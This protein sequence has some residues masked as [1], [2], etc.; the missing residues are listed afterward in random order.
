LRRTAVLTVMVALASVSVWAV[1]SGAIASPYA[2][3]V[4]VPWSV[5]AFVAITAMTAAPV[6]WVG[7]ADSRLLLT[8]E[9]SVAAPAALL[10][11]TYLA[12]ALVTLA[13]VAGYGLMLVR[14]SG[15][16]QPRANG[17]H[18]L[19]RACRG[20]MLV[21]AVVLVGDL[22]GRPGPGL[23]TASV[24]LGWA[25]WSATNAALTAIVSRPAGRS[26]PW[27]RAG[28]AVETVDVVLAATITALAVHTPFALPAVLVVCAATLTAH[29]IGQRTYRRLASTEP[30]LA[31]ALAAAESESPAEVCDLAAET[32]R[33]IL[34]HEVVVSAIVGHDGRPQVEFCTLGT[35]PDTPLD[36]RWVDEAVRSLAATTTLA[37]AAADRR[38]Q[39]REQA[40]RDPLTG[41][42]N[43]LGAERI[44][45]E[46]VA[47]SRRA[48]GEA[49]VA[50]IDL[51]G[52]KRANDERGHDA[53]DA[54]L[55]QAAE[56]LLGAVR[57]GDLVARLAGDEFLLVVE[58]IDPR[59][60][61]S[62]QDRV[63]QALEP[64]PEGASVGW[65]HAGPDGDTLVELQT[66]AE[67][68][69][70]DAKD[71]HYATTGSARR[72]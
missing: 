35:G 24:I 22:L 46:I 31:F 38:E 10:L 56:A 48:G 21:G 18:L 39:L 25:L 11:P 70:R 3:T 6:W 43:R 32:C 66:V 29:R 20:P 59:A 61:A 41:V 67:G 23:A 7:P 15:I 37:I 54:L 27:W 12:P 65:A 58:R 71:H 63:E 64:L 47:R 44:G 51:N 55:L 26:T 5:G 17:Q 16:I 49:A 62:L 40:L 53:G 33:A 68:R 30:L 4:S 34:G 69:M 28:V 14:G 42:H 60:A 45:H 19:Y 57:P 9:M 13:F 8:V 2:G 50:F 1:L 52:L 72:R 36:S